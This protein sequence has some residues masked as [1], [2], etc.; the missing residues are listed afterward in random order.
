MIEVMTP[1]REVSCVEDEPLLPRTA[2]I[3]LG[4]PVLMIGIGE[5]TESFLPEVALFS[6]WGLIATV[7]LSCGIFTIWRAQKDGRSCGLGLCVFASIV[8]GF[9]LFSLIVGLLLD[10]FRVGVCSGA[11]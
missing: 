10:Y 6:I 3:A 8:N 5:L 7:G 4:S 2:W 1:D 9:F 11:L